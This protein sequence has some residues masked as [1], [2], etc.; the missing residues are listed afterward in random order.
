MFS[1]QRVRAILYY[2]SVLAF[3]LGLPLILSSALG[4]KF[5]PRTFKFTQTGLISIKTQPPGATIYLDSRLFNDK[6]PASISELLPGYYNLRLELDGYSPWEMQVDVQARKVTR[7]E[8]VILFSKRP[9]IKQ[10]NENNI[11]SF[12]VDQDRKLIY[13]FNRQDNIIY[14]SDLEGERFRQLTSLPER[15]KGLPKGFRFSADKE[16]AAIFNNNQICVLYLSPK[17]SLLYKEAPLILDYPGEKVIQVFWHSDSYHLIVVTARNI[18]VIETNVNS[19]ELILVNLNKAP[20]DLFYDQ[21]KDNL[22]FLDYQM[23]ADGAV[24]ENVYKLDLSSKVSII[25]NLVKT[26]HNDRE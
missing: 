3:F 2:L 11:S 4:Y 22:Y 8:K 10:L 16:K 23:G 1:E 15:F 19:N 24:Y 21:D 7:V 18:S 12:Y 25:S 5:N 17:G 13:Y 9:N 6:S 20:S 14:E 26:R